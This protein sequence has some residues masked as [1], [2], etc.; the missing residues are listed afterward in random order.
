MRVGEGSRTLP[1]PLHGPIFTPSAIVPIVPALSAVVPALS[2][3]VP[4]WSEG[5]NFSG[6]PTS[7]LI[8]GEDFKDLLGRIILSL[9]YR[10]FFLDVTECNTPAT[11]YS[12]KCTLLPPYSSLLLFQGEELFGRIKSF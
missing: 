8:I 12:H 4:L 11:N 3:V 5:I 10:F 9:L 1:P 6:D 7:S 2:A